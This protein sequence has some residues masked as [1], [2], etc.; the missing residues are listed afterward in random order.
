MPANTTADRKARM[1]AWFDGMSQYTRP[2]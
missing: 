2:A 1:N